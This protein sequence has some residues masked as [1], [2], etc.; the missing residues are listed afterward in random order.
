MKLSHKEEEL[1]ITLSVT[2]SLY[3]AMYLPTP[4][5]N[6]VQISTGNTASL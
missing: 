1:Y 3:N 5:N 4:I 6:N 2:Q